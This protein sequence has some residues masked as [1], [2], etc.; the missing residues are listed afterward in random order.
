MSR[1]ATSFVLGYHGCDRRTAET[2]LSGKE[3]IKKSNRDF[4]WLGPG[5]Y[6]WEGDPHRAKEWA[7]AQVERKRYKTA[8]VIGAVIDLGNCLDL[9]IRKNVGIFKGAYSDFLA[10]QTKAGL[11]VPENGNAPDDPHEDRLL[12]RLDCAVFHHLH[13]GI[14]EE[15]SRGTPIESFDTVRGMFTEGGRLYNGCGFFERTHVQIAVCNLESI[16]GLFRPLRL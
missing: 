16:I 6:F 11:P 2:L 3:P 5:A 9:S 15:I 12:R 13:G 10:H 8:A 14:E 7:D 1:Q 4:D